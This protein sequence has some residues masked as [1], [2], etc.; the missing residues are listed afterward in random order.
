LSSS[1]RASGAA[2]NGEKGDETITRMCVASDP[3]SLVAADIHRG[4]GL[5]ASPPVGLKTHYSKH[6]PSSGAKI[7]VVNSICWL[8]CIA[9]SGFVFMPF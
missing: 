6:V 8:F 4:L 5:R 2:H 3:V 1:R 9:L 7:I